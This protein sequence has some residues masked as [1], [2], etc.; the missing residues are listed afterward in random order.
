[1]RPV[2]RSVSPVS[3]VFELKVDRDNLNLTPS[4]GEVLNNWVKDVS[5][6]LFA[7]P[8]EV[9]KMTYVTPSLK[10]FAESI[11]SKLKSE[12]VVGGPLQRS[13]GFG[14][15][16]ALIF[17]W[18][19]FTSRDFYKK[20][21]I[22]INYDDDVIKETLVLGMDYSYEEPFKTLYEVLEAYAEAGKKNHTI[23]EVKDEYLLKAVKEV[24]EKY[25]NDENE[26]TKLL[27]D[28]ETLAEVI[29]SILKKYRDDYE[30]KPRLLLLIDEL[31]YGLEVRLRTYVNGLVN[32]REDAKPY[33][34]YGE[35]QKVLTFLDQLYRKLKNLRGA[36]AVVI[37]VVAEQDLRAIEGLMANKDARD[38]IYAI[39]QDLDIFAQRYGRAEGGLAFAEPSYDPDHALE[40]ARYRVLDI[41]GGVRD[42]DEYVTKLRGLQDDYAA[43]LDVT[44][45]EFNLASTLAIYKEELRRHYPF[46]LGLIR[47]LKKLMSSSDVPRTEFVRTV[48]RVAYDASE[49]ALQDNSARAV[50]LK[51]L[52]AADEPG[53]GSVALPSLMGDVQD[54]WLDTV[55]DIVRAVKG[56]SDQQELST[57]AEVAAKYILA[58]G[59]TANI[60]ELLGE[61]RKYA[62]Q[63]GST[64]EDIQLE[65]VETFADDEISKIINVLDRALQE[66]R[67]RSARID[68][69]QAPAQ[70]K[71]YYVPA[72]IRTIYS[73]LASYINDERNKLKDDL[74]YIPVYIK[75]STEVPQLFREIGNVIVDSRQNDVVTV[76]VDYKSIKDIGTLLSKEEVR[77]ALNSGKLL[78]AIVPP[79]DEDLLKEIY[80]SKRAYVDQAGEG[81]S[82]I[83]DV[84][85]KLSSREAQEALLRPLHL[86]ILL[87]DLSEHLL[88]GV[89]DKLIEYQGIKRF[90]NEYLRE[91]RRIIETNVDTALRQL[92]SF[93]RRHED[94]DRIRQGLQGL[95][96]AQLNE[97]ERYAR[98]RLVNLSREISVDVVRLYRRAIHFS[99]DKNAFTATDLERARAS[100]EAERSAE[101]IEEKPDLKDY[102]RVIN[103]FL[104]RVVALLGYVSDATK[105]ADAILDR[106]KEEQREEPS[107]SKIYKISDVIQN[108]MLGVYKVKPL[109]ED[110]AREAVRKLNGQRIE[111]DNKVVEIR[112]NE[113]DNQIEFSVRE[114][115][116]EATSE[117]GPALE[118]PLPTPQA[119][120]VGRAAAGSS[121]IQL[122]SPES[123]VQLLLHENFN[124]DDIRKKMAELADYL[125][126]I[127][128]EVETEAMSMRVELRS[129]I[130]NALNDPYVI[131][132]LNLLSRTR[133][134][135]QLTMYLAKPVEESRVKEIFGEYFKRASSFDKLLPT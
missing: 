34:I 43:W 27:A 31:G 109:S 9:L 91:K 110:V 86:V 108:I 118:S 60:I 7:K 13:F 95:I 25:M 56:I 22:D 94:E 75:N 72:P 14:K 125:N 52:K 115:K 3:K 61:T 29:A 113:K 62:E 64:I 80:L 15:T 68:E 24:L 107:S 19:L 103:A 37:W 90:L 35:V 124:P 30:K 79:W 119:A 69:V 17:L 55:A 71:T 122:L 111:L 101:K 39:L 82:I 53:I 51:H 129:P 4:F 66:L 46:S 33:S 83:S 28:P 89:L 44:A 87:P 41:A 104:S 1:M 99:I 6:Y 96:E 112:V 42:Q 16:H 65:I 97:A 59:A 93:I 78:I 11:V 123:P 23:A 8:D 116:R 36:A 73:A 38:K 12:G 20:A 40:I 2:V 135:V 21:G 133:R 121:P 131:T 98:S 47:L 10:K 130:R 114:L 45:K 5:K 57:A 106:F 134:P 88:R 70:G 92:E 49:K 54:I 128:L 120:T 63:Y 50:G 74:M 100:E 85:S 26:K 127:K 48:I 126:S 32:G 67:V 84:I 81:S 102:A 18:H 58:K 117:A 105:V 77:R 132:L 76:S